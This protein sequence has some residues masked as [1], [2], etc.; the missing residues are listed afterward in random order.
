L[1]RSKLFLLLFAALLASRVCHVHILWEGDAY[2][3]AAA[4]QMLHGKMLYRDIWFDK[5]PLLALAYLL[6]GAQAGW[7]LR[8]ADALYA[9]LACWIAYGF[10]RDLWSEREGLWAAGL[11]A[12]F[13]LFD[14]PSA[15][16]PVA[17]DLLMLAPHLAAVWLAWKRRPF[18]SGAVAAAAFWISP[19]GLFIAAAC[20]LWDPAGILWMAAG[21]AAGSA[22]A[23][24]GLSAGGALG[25][26]WEQVWQWGRLYAASPFV[27][28]PLRNG[29]SRTLNW[30]GFHVALVAAAGWFLREKGRWRWIGWVLVAAVGVA[31]GLRF[32]PRYYFLLLPPLVLMAARGFPSLGRGAVWAALLL[33]IPAARFGPSYVTAARSAAWRDT[34]MD[35]DSRAAAAIVKRLAA[36]GDTLFVWGYR[37]ELYVYT[38]L[39]AATRYLD[40]QPLTGVPADRHL[41]RSEA[42][43]IVE[44]AQRRAALIRSRP[45][46]LVDGLA[47]YN[48][49]LAIG[50]YAELR[51]WLAGYEEAART[52]GT[53]IY[54]SSMARAF[55]GKP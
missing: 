38:G 17:S 25:A 26:Y 39:P 14:V 24:A 23:V 42:I 55:P 48:P 9:L 18:W 30:A 12:F 41:T 50:N 32:F 40:S 6:C 5:P 13:L 16:I 33:L 8:L 21:F 53:I 1:S 29:I 19:K 7:P 43:E 11:L 36:P 4:Q 54:R 28:A 20:V 3:L 27:E 45:T 35:R 51:P 31:A 46:F 2:P 49:T 44:S 37:P 15:V 10:A 22:V 52:G 34:A 47:P